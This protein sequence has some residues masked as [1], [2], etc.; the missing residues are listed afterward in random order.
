M[1][2]IY[3]D[4]TFDGNLWLNAF[5]LKTVFGN[6][7]TTIQS[8]KSYYFEYKLENYILMKNIS[9]EQV[10]VIFGGIF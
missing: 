9:T 8:L 7:Q 4:D 1:A 5:T 3:R 10:S 2:I 6:L